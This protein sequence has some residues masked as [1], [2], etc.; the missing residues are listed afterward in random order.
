[1]INIGFWNIKKNQS[2]EFCE[3]LADFV[4]K[5]SLDIL[6]L[7]EC[8]LDMRIFLQ[9]HELRRQQFELAHYVVPRR[10]TCI[11]YSKKTLSCKKEPVIDQN[12]HCMNRFIGNG[13]DFALCCV[14]LPSRLHC[15]ESTRELYART[16][17]ADLETFE[18]HAGIR[19]TIIVGD[20]NSDPFDDT[21][22]S[23][24]GFHSLPDRNKAKNGRKMKG[25]YYSAFY[26]PMWNMYGDFSAPAGTYYY[27]NSEVKN[28]YWYI[29][30]QVI[31]RHEML[32]Y[33]EE[34]SLQIATDIPGMRN[35]NG[36]PNI[37]DHFPIVF[38]LK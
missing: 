11:L 3:V 22:L 10:D 7:C 15:Q 4:T 1:M 17:L 30:D 37:S 32:T 5:Y 25:I 13:L 16:V 34:E 27:D 20:F 18:K 36:R 19:N 2:S 28:Q 6:A 29:Y 21:M 9:I 14:H 8:P 12:D 31:M 23:L 26:N 35:R 33:F 24:S 38:S